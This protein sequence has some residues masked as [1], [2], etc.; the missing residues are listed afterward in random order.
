MPNLTNY[1]GLPSFQQ[2][3]KNNI[4]FY[5]YT[6]IF[7]KPDGSQLSASKRKNRLWLGIIGTIGYFLLLLIQIKQTKSR[8]IGTYNSFLQATYLFK[9]LFVSGVH[10]PSLNRGSR[11]IKT[12]VASTPKW[13]L[14]T[15]GVTPPDGTCCVDAVLGHAYCYLYFP[16]RHWK[17]SA[18]LG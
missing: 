17:W 2:I 8:A 1:D 10:H 6:L 5:F 11:G 7:F 12:H 18:K 15:C 4:Y 16:L 3:S 13:K 9:L 14:S